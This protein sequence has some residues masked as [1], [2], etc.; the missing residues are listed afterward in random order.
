MPSS[1]NPFKVKQK[2]K[3]YDLFISFYGQFRANYRGK[4]DTEPKPPQLF[5]MCGMSR[6]T[7]DTQ[8]GDKT[9]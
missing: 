2:E 8:E 6:K 1:G 3:E 4:G 5:L 7:F 9:E